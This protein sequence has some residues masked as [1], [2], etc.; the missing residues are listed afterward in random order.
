MKFYARSQCLGI[1]LDQV[2]PV[3]VVVVQGLSIS[4]P[5][6]NRNADAKFGLL[7][8]CCRHFDLFE[9]LNIFF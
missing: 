9:M 7:Y 8:F 3:E 6:W 4:Q 1:T 2:Y 5:L